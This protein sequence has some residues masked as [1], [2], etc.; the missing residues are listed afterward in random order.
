MI[1]LAVIA[2]VP[3]L[4]NL[5]TQGSI[6]MALTHLVAQYPAYAD[7]FL[8][9]SQTGV[10]VI[11]DNSA[12]ELET[13]TGHGLPA[14][15]VLS[16]ARRVG[17]A[18]VICQDV[19]YDGPATLAATR[20]FLT[21][22][23]GGPYQLMAVPQGRDRTEWL[24]CY[25]RLIDLPGVDIIGLSKLSLPRSFAAPVAEA[26]LDCVS[27]LLNDEVLGT[28]RAPPT[29]PRP[30]RGQQRLVVRVLVPGHRHPGPRHQR[31]GHRRGT[32]QA[33][34][35]RHHPDPRRPRPR[36]PVHTPTAPGRRPRR[37][38]PRPPRR[39][40]SL[41]PALTFVHLAAQ[42]DGLHHWPD[43]A[44]PDRYLQSPHRHLFVVTVDLQV[45]HD[46]REVEINA[47][48]RWLTALLP[49][50]SEVPRIAAGPVDFG[51][52]SCEQLANRITEAIKDRHGQRR[53][54]TTTVLED[55][56]LGA[57]IT[58]RPDMATEPGA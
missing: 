55:G 15:P 29:R 33:G 13:D 20:R 34:P 32:R 51:A 9:R 25:H 46:D 31:P 2:G 36:Q 8:T 10:R 17:A 27:T 53:H 43:A 23:A 26:R 38:Q 5:S 16:A 54:I 11:L 1:D 30:R 19:L 22:A 58:W 18:V 49:T 12:Y 41:M 37:Q 6:D 24:D 14:A 52:Q 45:F 56:I 4:H 21:E 28:R 44:D 35:D 7:Y 40:G 50:L 39:A 3:H 47:A 42:V 48:A 57:G